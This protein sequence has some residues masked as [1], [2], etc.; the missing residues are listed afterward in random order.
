MAAQ[1]PTWEQ[2]SWYGG[3][4]DDRFLGLENSFRYA[5]GVEI[6]KNPYSLTLAY[7]AEKNSATTVDTLINKM[8]TIKSTG[9][10]IGFGS[11]G[12]IFRKP[13][14][15]GAWELVYTD[16]G[17]AKIF[18][19]YEY[20]S[21]LYWAT[22]D[23]LHRIAVTNIDADWSGF[24]TEDY[25]VFA[26]DNASYHPMLEVFNKLFVGDGYYLAEL[27]SFGVWTD[28][29]LKIFEDEVI[30]VITFSGQYMRFYAEKSHKVDQSSK[31][32]WN[33]SDTTYNERIPYYQIIHSAFV[34]RGQDYVIA[35]VHPFIY[36]SS[37]YELTE[38]KRL[39]L[40]YD[41]EKFFMSSNAIDVYDNLLIFA[42][43][44]SGSTAS[45]GRGIWTWGRENKNY[46]D[47][48]NFDYPTSN[49]NATDLIGCVH[50]SNGVLYMAWSNAGGTVFGIDVINTAKFRATGELHSRVMHG[51]DPAHEKELRKIAI[52]FDKLAA[53]EKIQTFFRKN[54]ATTWEASAELTVDYDVTADR[55]IY[56]KDQ[57]DA[58]EIGDFVFLESKILLTAG[59]SQATT[60]ELVQVNIAFDER[61]EKTD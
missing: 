30:K 36:L 51:N 2:K 44:S 28:N 31:Y 27:D 26:N 54:L 18:D 42:P 60:P 13:T 40:V 10:I 59:T 20:N 17:T 34:Y 49:D 21:Y 19:G 55:D 12:K 48:L 58:A 43:A 15:T 46:P 38:V 23:A 25:K 3:F 50:N 37:G 52:S 41:S 4:S 6:R 7:A 45:I 61:I 47:S 5:K 29:K 16:T 32:F 39:P 33:V 22:S 1:F 57:D 56:F 35:G 14:G 9:D 24:V 53:G 8:L 11:N